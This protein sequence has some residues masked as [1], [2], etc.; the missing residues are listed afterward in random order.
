MSSNNPLDR[1]R[2][3]SRRSVGEHEDKLS[4][5]E[6]HDGDRTDDG[7]SLRDRGQDR[8]ANDDTSGAQRMPD[9]GT[10][11]ARE[12]EQFGGIKFGSAFFGWLTATGT[13]VLL[14]ALA[15]AVGTVVSLATDTAAGDVVNQATQDP[16]TVGITGAVI[17]L[18]ILFIAYYCGG[19]VAGR[20]ARF[21]GA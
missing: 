12:K 7:P 6:R 2:G 21:D 20:M 10:V 1:L 16:Q 11:V 9:R 8:L 19:Y 18:A 17:L 5:N 15:A 3:G 4:V 13:A 14:T